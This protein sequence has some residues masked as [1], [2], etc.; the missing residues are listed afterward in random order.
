MFVQIAIALI[1]VTAI[2]GATEGMRDMTG[3]AASAAHH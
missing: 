1:L 2:A 3:A